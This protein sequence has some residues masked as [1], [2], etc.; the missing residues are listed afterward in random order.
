VAGSAQ[1]RILDVVRTSTRQPTIGVQARHEHPAADAAEERSRAEPAHTTRTPTERSSGERTAERNLVERTQVTRNRTERNR[2][3]VVEELR[4]KLAAR[5]STA[6]TP[7]R[8]VPTV[9]ALPAFGDLLPERGLRRGAS[10]SVQRSTMLTLALL[11]GA[12]RAGSWC[13]I[14]GMPGFGAEAA[15]GLGIDL[16]RII[17]VP[18]PGRLWL[19][20]VAT[21]VDV[22]D[23]VVVRPPARPYDAEAQ[24][25]AARIRERGAVLLAQRP[26]WPGCEL[27]LAITTST[28]HGLGAGHGHLTSREVTVEATGRS[29]GGRRRTT[30]LWLPDRAGEVRSAEPAAVTD[31]AGDVDAKARPTAGAVPAAETEPGDLLELAARWERAG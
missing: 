15:A 30:R 4:A 5:P 27:R 17:L 24:R 18:A 22:L 28:W 8:A 10:Y 1:G 12:S 20:V 6:T 19:T 29:T 11:A 25:L 7:G 9:P 23:V 16:T 14:V 2:A 21:L 31:L 13:G 26:D 3:A